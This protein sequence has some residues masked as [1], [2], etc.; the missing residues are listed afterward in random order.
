VELEEERDFVERLV[1]C[2]GVAFARLVEMHCEMVYNLI[3]RIVNDRDLAEDLSQ[4][5]FLKVYRG[6][7]SFGRRS[8]L[9][10]W[11]YRIAYNVAI[12]ETRKPH[13][14]HETMELEEAFGEYSRSTDS[15]DREREPLDELERMEK[16]ETVRKHI[17]HLEPRQR[18]ALTLYYQGGKSYREISKIMEVPIGTVKTLIFRSKEALRKMIGEIE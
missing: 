6:L 2:D 11:I 13:Y 16:I 4:E 12:T 18:A 15:L 8:S 1:S 14:R 3:L 10:T 9:S 5:T 7:P 17:A